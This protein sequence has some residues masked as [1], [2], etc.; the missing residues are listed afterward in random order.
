LR[1]PLPNKKGGA[2]TRIPTGK[3]VEEFDLKAHTGG[4][5]RNKID[6]VELNVKEKWH[7]VLGIAPGVDL[8]AW[9]YFAA[10]WLSWTAPDCAR[11]TD[12]AESCGSFH[13]TST[14]TSSS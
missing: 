9:R 5:V 14:R 7:P 8:G 2:L 1:H 10:W 4:W 12:T 6:F 13:A 11:Y 3:P